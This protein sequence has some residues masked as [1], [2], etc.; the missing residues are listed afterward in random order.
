M[1][2]VY[3]FHGPA[4]LPVLADSKLLRKRKKGTVTPFYLVAADTYSITDKDGTRPIEAYQ[5]VPGQR[6]LTLTKRESELIALSNA[7]VQPPVV[8]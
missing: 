6:S 1:S 5:C 8:L 3:R 2:R 7:G 4:Y